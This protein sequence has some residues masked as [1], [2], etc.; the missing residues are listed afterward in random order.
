MR[1]HLNIFIAVIMTVFAFA[2]IANAQLDDWDQ[3]RFDRTFA[4]GNRTIQFPPNQDGYRFLGNIL[5]PG[6]LEVPG[7]PPG[8]PYTVE[9]L[10][11]ARVF[12]ANEQGGAGG[13]LTIRVNENDA[14]GRINALRDSRTDLSTRGV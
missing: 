4:P 6:D 1:A 11:G 12:F 9:I 2:T 13:S 5:I 7:D 10:P 3:D 8:D 14:V